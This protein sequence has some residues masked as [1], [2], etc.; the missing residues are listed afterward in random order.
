MRRVGIL[1]HPRR[2]ESQAV[3]EE[4]ART[5]E[6]RGLSAWTDTSGLIQPD[7]LKESDFVVVIGGDGAILRAARLCAPFQVPVFGL[8]IGYL[9]FLTEAQ[10][11]QWEESLNRILAGHYWI[12]SRLMITGSVW[13]NGECILHEDALNDVVVGRGAIAN[14]T[15]LDA[16]IN[17]EWATSYN[18]D[19]VIIATATGSTAYAL[20]AGG[21][22]LPPELDNIL[23]VPVAPH[24]S[25]ERPVILAQGATVKI[26]VSPQNEWDTVVT[27]DGQTVVEL[28]GGD[29][30]EVRASEKRSHFIRLQ[31]RNYFFR[32]LMDRMEPRFLPKHPPGR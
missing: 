25:M 4:V 24:F 11:P 8:N 15:R 10:P 16:Y 1:A 30:V 31:G 32:S 3:M 28:N 9:G 2:P 12:E 18:A 22:I 26:V 29:S 19:G 21:P 5:V 6:A 17:D 13:K 14:A 23:L 20:A 27:I 7:S